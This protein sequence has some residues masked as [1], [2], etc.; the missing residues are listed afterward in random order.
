MDGPP[1]GSAPSTLNIHT[2]NRPLSPP[3]S[4]S[5]ASLSMLCHS[6]TGALWQAPTARPE[7]A[8]HEWINATHTN[9]QHPPRTIRGPHAQAQPPSASPGVPGVPGVSLS[10]TLL[11]LSPPPF[12]LSLFL[13]HQLPAYQS[14]VIVTLFKRLSAT[15]ALSSTHPQVAHSHFRS[16]PVSSDSI[17]LPFT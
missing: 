11:L 9:T 10:L 3:S 4:F 16:F 15:H 14:T 5:R 8:H 13:N 12:L 7:Q 17:H 6:Q 1:V 2:T